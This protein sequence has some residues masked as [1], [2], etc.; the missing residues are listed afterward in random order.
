MVN[1][2][3]A[4]IDRIFPKTID[5]PGPVTMQQLADIKAALKK[6]LPADSTVELT[7]LM[8]TV[9]L[10]VYLPKHGWLAPRSCEVTH[11]V[12]RAS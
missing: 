8:Q 2:A 5:Q 10:S 1:E 7:L 3:N 11:D 6:E 4:V 9:C 12:A